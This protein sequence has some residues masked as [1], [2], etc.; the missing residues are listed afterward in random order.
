M[1]FQAEIYAIKACIME[2][3]EEGYTGSNIYFL[4]DRQAAIKALKTFQMKFQITV[5]LPSMHG[6]IGRT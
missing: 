2:N 4:S 1:E 3:I 5:E 6:E